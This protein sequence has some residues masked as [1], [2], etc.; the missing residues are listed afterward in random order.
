MATERQLIKQARQWKKSA[1]VEI[2]DRYS[3]GLYRYALRL[4][5]KPSAAED[6]VADTFERFLIALKRGGGPKDYLQA[7]LYRM[8]H[9]WVSDYYR[10]ARPDIDELDQSM[11]SAEKTDENVLRKMESQEI[12][13]ALSK[14]SSEQRQV[15]SL[16]HLEGLKNKEVALIMEKSVG[17]VKALEHRGLA[18]L[19]RILN[20][21]AGK[22]I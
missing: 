14:I 9:N 13:L 16:K 5:G 17:A 22:A 15:I 21:A 12:Q 20:T 8:A 10:K 4:L 11:A 2:Y 6:C 18:K 1:L 7:Y 19:E 3:P